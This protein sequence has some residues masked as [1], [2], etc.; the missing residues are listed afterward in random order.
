MSART[1]N[2]EGLSHKRTRRPGEPEGRQT[3]KEIVIFVLMC[4]FWGEGGLLF[5][6][7][8]LQLSMLELPN[9]LS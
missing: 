8:R 4:F 1:W 5:K 7:K 6:E 3:L 2:R 9:H